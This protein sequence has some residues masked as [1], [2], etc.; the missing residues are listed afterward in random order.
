MPSKAKMSILKTHVHHNTK[1]VSIVFINVRQV[2][3]VQIGKEAKKLNG[4]CCLN[5]HQINGR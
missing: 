1:L 4:H 5:G 2:E 3:S